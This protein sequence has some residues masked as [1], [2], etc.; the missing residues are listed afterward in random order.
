[1]VQNIED[2]SDDKSLKF[3]DNALSK[4]ECPNNPIFDNI[5]KGKYIYYLIKFIEYMPY[6]HQEGKKEKLFE[7]EIKN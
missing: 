3:L 6:H 5:L 4:N 7:K 1:M 2:D